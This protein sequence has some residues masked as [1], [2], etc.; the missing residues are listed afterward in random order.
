MTRVERWERRTE[1]PLILLALAFLVAYAWPVLDQSLPSDLRTQLTICSWTVWVAFAADFSV[2]VALADERVAYVRRHWYDAVL[3]LVPMLRPLRLLR[4]LAFAR[5][6]SRSAVGSLVGR[7]TA[8]VFGT[9]VVAVG[10]AAI[11]V[12]DVE[13]DAPDATIRTFGDALWWAATTVTTV[14]YGDFYPVTVQGR[15]I[16]V[17]LMI[18]GIGTVGAVTAAVAAWFVGHVGTP[19]VATDGAEPPATAGARSS[20]DRGLGG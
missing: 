17:G 14:G 5:I 16:A 19:P 20:T 8:Y 3:I 15:V 12:L 18:I 13:Q 11:A 9:A 6:L 4:L 2:R 7:V 1:V 10:L